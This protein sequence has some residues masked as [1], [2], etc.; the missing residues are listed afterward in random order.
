MEAIDRQL[1]RAR[2]GEPEALSALYRQ[3]LPGVFGSI[4]ARVPDRATAEDLTSEVFV[5][6]VEGISRLRASDEAGVAAWILQ[7][8]RVTVAGYS[9]KCERQ[10]VFVL[11][12]PRFWEEETAGENPVISASNP[13]LD[14]ARRAEA[15][16]EWDAVVQ[17]INTPTEEQR[18]VLV[19]RL[20]L[21]YDVA[22]VARM[23]GKK[24]SAIK[25]LQ[26]RALQRLQRVFG[27]QHAP[28][29][30]FPLHTRQKEDLAPLQPAL[31]L[32]G[33]SSKRIARELKGL[34]LWL[35]VQSEWVS[36]ACH[37]GKGRPCKGT[38]PS[39]MQWQVKATVTVDQQCVQQEVRRK[40][41]FIVATNMLDS[42]ELSDEELVTTYKE[43]GGVECGF[44]FLKDPLFLASSVFLKKPERIVALSLIMVL[45]L[46]VY[47]L[48]EHRL[49]A[50]LAQT[51][52]TLQSC[53]MWDLIGH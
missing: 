43:Q 4:A 20:I 2:R 32:S 13:E 48:A 8:A 14:P 46:L 5:K 37:A 12:E 1:D 3:L 10:P 51:E 38:A 19:G 22:T 24:A 15:R 52:Q 29:H 17:A 27:K 47:R 25:A 33:R 7:I 11:L 35:D 18:Q 31:R 45:C 16:D 40:A 44:R 21:G 39:S 26:F 34:P 49:R 23:L 9:R 50:R 42:A 41:C 36:Q 28:E 6:M 30:A 53:G